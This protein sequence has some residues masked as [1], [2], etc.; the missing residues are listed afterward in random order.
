MTEDTQEE[1]VT[2]DRI[3]IDLSGIDSPYSTVE[4]GTYQIILA[5]IKLDRSKTDR[6]MLR[7]RWETTHPDTGEQVS[8]FDYPLLD[9]QRGKFR[10]KQ[11]LIAAGIDPD[12][13]DGSVAELAGVAVQAEVE[14][15]DS[16]D[17]GEQNRVRQ[18]LVEVPKAV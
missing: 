4:D 10:L 11:L 15:E 5:D 16:E 1:Q 8:M 17:Y 3:D 18:I 2:E 13:W 6:P 14:K 12:S 9:Q 7:C